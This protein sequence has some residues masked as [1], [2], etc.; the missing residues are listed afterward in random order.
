MA[1]A[2]VLVL[3]ALAWRAGYDGA[4]TLLAIALAF[5][6]AAGLTL[7]SGMALIRQIVNP[8]DF[9]TV[10]GWNQVSGRVM[11]LLGAP[12]GGILVAWGGLV[13]AMV[14]DAATFAVIAVVLAL[15]V[16]A[17]YRL[18]RAEEAR[19]RD[20]FV[21]G[22]GYLRRTPTARTFVIGL[23]ALNVFVS[24][25]VALGLALR[26][27]GSAW[28]PAWLGIAD[29]ALAGGAIVGSL[30]AIRWQPTYAAGSGFRVLVL[31][32]VG[33]AVV[34]VPYVPV[35]L[36]GMLTVGVTAGHGERV[37][38]G[39]VPQGG[40]RGVHRPRLLG[41]QPRRHDPDAA[42][43]A[44]PRRPRRRDERAAGHGRL[45]ALDVGAVPVVRDPTRDRRP[46]LTPKV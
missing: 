4:P 14:V 35:V 9:G 10:M 8:D 6:V 23:T 2:A 46:Q 28:G 22:M 25:V 36:V 21:A 30:A 44:G 38:V 33:L 1:R 32:G 31:Q 41:H 29:A 18:P 24:P 27:E 5:G 45:R 19:W 37:A 42:V 3:G 26:V 11:R 20:S 15:V 13:A 39:R 17:R 12:V 43:D 7:P 40:R 16:R 34:G